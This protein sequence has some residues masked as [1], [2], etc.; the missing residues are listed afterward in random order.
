MELGY[1][2]S[3]CDDR[4]RA[5]AREGRRD[6]GASAARRQRVP[7]SGVARDRGYL[8]RA[9]SRLEAERARRR[10][11][12]YA[13]LQMMRAASLREQSFTPQLVG[14]SLKNIG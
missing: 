10:V 11:P 8:Q 13:G 3:V 12:A 1:S 9:R 5:E 14:V 4:V 6:R 2:D 7:V